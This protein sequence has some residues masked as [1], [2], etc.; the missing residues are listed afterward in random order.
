LSWCAIYAAILTEIAEQ[1]RGHVIRGAGELSVH[2]K[3]QEIDSTFEIVTGQVPW[4]GQYHLCLDFFIYTP[5][6]VMAQAIC[7]DLSLPLNQTKSKLYGLP[8]IP[9]YH[10]DPTKDY[11][12]IWDKFCVLNNRPNITWNDQ[13][14]TPE[15]VIHEL[16]QKKSRSQISNTY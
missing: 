2:F 1:H 13:Y 7:S 14:C 10:V 8:M 16:A 11:Q 5:E 15:Q 9:K 4:L 12:D 6:I 3:S